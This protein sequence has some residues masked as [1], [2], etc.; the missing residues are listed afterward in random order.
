MLEET[1]LFYL[2]QASQIFQIVLVAQ[3]STSRQIT[4][5]QLSWAE[6]EGKSSAII[7][8]PQALTTEE[9]T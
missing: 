3:E 6:D 7:T 5:L 4:L 9:A 2:E 1:D 8:L